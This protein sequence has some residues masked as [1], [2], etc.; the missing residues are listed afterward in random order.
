MFS[1]LSFSLASSVAVIQSAVHGFLG[2]GGFCCF[3]PYPPPPPFRPRRG[4]KGEPEFGF[5]SST[6]AGFGTLATDVERHGANLPFEASADQFAR[7]RSPAR[8]AR[9]A[10]TAR[11]R[12]GSTTTLLV[13][14]EHV[15]ALGDALTTPI[16]RHGTRSGRRVRASA[17]WPSDNCWL[18]PWCTSAHCNLSPVA[19]GRREGARF[20]P[21]RSTPAGE[22]SGGTRKLSANSA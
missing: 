9:T 17:S 12:G 15:E 1:S 5:S 4:G 3:P 13:R 2:K 21:P 8:C 16:S 18:T 20:R 14:T 19:R 7:N 6:A 10:R 22:V 11:T